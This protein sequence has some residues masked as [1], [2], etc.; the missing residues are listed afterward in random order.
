MLCYML[1]LLF[2]YDNVETQPEISNEE[3]H[4]EDGNIASKEAIART[5]PE[6]SNQSSQTSYSV[7]RIEKDNWNNI[8]EHKGKG[9]LHN[10]SNYCVTYQIYKMFKLIHISLYTCMYVFVH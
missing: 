7:D 1:N 10:I 4:Q 9:F 3:I 8:A 5:D 2:H 6:A